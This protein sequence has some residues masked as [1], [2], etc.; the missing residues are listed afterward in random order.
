MAAAFAAGDG[1]AGKRASPGSSLHVGLAAEE[2]DVVGIGVSHGLID[3]VEG[4][5]LD[6]LDGNGNGKV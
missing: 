5:W 4:G 6:G 3:L 2:G 1:A